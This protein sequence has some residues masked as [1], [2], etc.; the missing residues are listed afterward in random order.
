MSKTNKVYEKLMAGQSDNNFAFEDLLYLL[1]KLGFKPHQSGSHIVCKKGTAFA[2][3]QPRC[4]KAKSYQLEEVRK[5]LKKH[6]IKP[7]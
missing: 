4:G 1:V 7:E 5:E 3:I 6:N 2:N